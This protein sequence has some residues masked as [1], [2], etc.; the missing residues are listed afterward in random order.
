MGVF[1]L[2]CATIQ[3]FKEYFVCPMFLSFAVSN[4]TA[5]VR[6]EQ[7]LENPDGNHAID[8]FFKV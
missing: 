3:V 2:S 5:L 1:G 4:F 6:T 7:M 8:S